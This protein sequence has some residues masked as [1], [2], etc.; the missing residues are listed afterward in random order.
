[1]QCTALGTG[2]WRYLQLGFWNNWRRLE[3]GAKSFM[4]KK[5][6][7]S[8]GSRQPPRTLPGLSL[9]FTQPNLTNDSWK[10]HDCGPM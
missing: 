8:E 1:M 9:S 3:A 7:C 6:D 5:P 10:P 4:R 2:P